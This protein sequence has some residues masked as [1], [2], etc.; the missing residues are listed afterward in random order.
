MNAQLP[1]LE[2]RGPNG[3]MERVDFKGDRLTIGRLHDV[4]DVAL[5]PD[6]QQLVTRHA[7][8][9][10]ERE[11]GGW[12]VVDNG[13]VNKTFLKRG[14]L[15]QIVAGSATL[16]PGDVVRILGNL[17]ESGEPEYWELTFYDPARTQR[18]EIAPVTA[19]LE[20]DWI[21]AKLFRVAGSTREEVTSLRP[22]EHKLIRYMDQRNRSN[23]NVPV[24]CEFEE[25][26][27]A[28]WGEGA[29]QTQDDVTHLAWE[30]RQKIEM[31]SSEP[32]FLQTVKG[33]GCRLETRPIA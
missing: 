3:Q 30:L 28:V 26:I 19:Y 33:L 18:A 21:Q 8:C 14:E 32:R 2:A 9:I 10:I 15:V 11:G 29:H 17:S 5:D 25:L 1:Y 12:K 7:H 13:S 27:S 23:G 24:M 20:Y 4:N 6:P 22:Q 16:L 31:D